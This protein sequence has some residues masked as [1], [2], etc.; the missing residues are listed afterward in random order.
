MTKK[1]A[2][3]PIIGLE[4]TVTG[5]R[6]I[7]AHKRGGEDE[8]RERLIEETTGAVVWLGG[9]KVINDYVGD[10]I[11]KK[12]FGGNFDV[13]KDKLRTPFDNFIKNNPN[14]RFTPKQIALIKAT[15]VL[16]SVLIADAFIGLVVPPLNQ[17]LTKNLRNKR[18][19]NTNEN[20]KD[21]LELSTQKSNKE[22]NPSFKGGGALNAI[23]VFTN[24][25]ENTNT[26]KLLSTDAGLVSGRMYSARNKEERREI[27]IRDIGSIY[28]YMWAQGHVG[29][30][31]NFAETGR[32]TRLDPN[33]ANIL[34]EYLTKFIESK[35]GEIGVDDFRNAFLGKNSS[36]IKIPEGIKFESEE[37]SKITKFFDK[38]RK[39]PTEP[40]QVVEVDDIIKEFTDDVIIKRIKAM[41]E[42]QPERC[43]KR[44]VTKQQII[45][46]MNI[47]E[48]NN[49]ELLDKV[50]DKFTGGAHKNK[51][52]YVSNKEL[53]SLK[54]QME[55][56]VAD[57]CK[58]AK[59]GKITKEIIKNA[60]NKNLIFSGINFVAGFAVAATF[61]S[62]LIPKF[63]YWYTKVT[64]GKH[65]F[66]GTYED[67]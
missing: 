21:K 1:D 57:I 55:D 19:N 10:P 36:E 22:T 67:K 62:T 3:G 53:Y 16:A 47:S 56:Y 65:E 42:L 44:V 48:I 17:K 6:T 32:L 24:A 54:A 60:K 37:L 39:V 25:I 15:K 49:P 23:N 31:L 43:G 7:Q 38:F 64:T 2:L 13:G 34:D 27:A 9:V 63:Q 33:S 12:L 52:K 35:G 14:K 28:F 66:P 50:F 40:L 8:A 26:G 20:T 11:L 4:A 45:D 30:V 61:L 59:N 5:G 29:N 51:Y 58:K 18:K 46:A 41:S